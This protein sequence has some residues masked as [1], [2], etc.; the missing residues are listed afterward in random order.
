MLKLYNSLPLPLEIINLKHF[1]NK[2]LLKVLEGNKLST[3]L[4]M[5]S[6]VTLKR[7]FMQSLALGEES[8]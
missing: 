7:N 5:S 1:L 6:G 4:Q 8:F 3:A 2:L